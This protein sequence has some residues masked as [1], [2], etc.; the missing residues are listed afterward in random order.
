[1]DRE[2]REAA[3]S[4]VH[5]AKQVVEQWK[6]S[7]FEVRAEIEE[8]GRH[9]R[10]E[11]DRKRLF[12]RTDYVASVCQDLYNVLQVSEHIFNTE[13]LTCVNVFKAPRFLKD[14]PHICVTKILDEFHNFFGPEL[15]GVTGEPK[16]IDEVLRRVI[17]LILP[18]EGINFKPFNICKMSS[19]K[20]IMQDFYNKVQVSLTSR[21]QKL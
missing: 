7:Y 17:S 16:H 5:D 12:E 21:T 2:K 3:K 4:K 1:M 6:T 13:S 14:V 19:W 9:P 8:S 11:F 18:I 15:K 10:W 20:T